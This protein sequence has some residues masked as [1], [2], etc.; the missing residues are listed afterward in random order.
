M[1]PTAGDM[2]STSQSRIHSQGQSSVGLLFRMAGNSDR[3]C[4]FVFTTAG[5]PTVLLNL[6]STPRCLVLAMS[7]YGIGGK[8]FS[9][10]EALLHD[11]AGFPMQVL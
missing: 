11:M 10:S 8:L 1:F 3:V 4:S 9:Q 2:N 6:A 5:Y 7:H